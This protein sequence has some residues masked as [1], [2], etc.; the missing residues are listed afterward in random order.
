MY[1][2]TGKINEWFDAHQDLST[3][4][5]A[6]TMKFLLQVKAKIVYIVELIICP[7]T[8][9]TFPAYDQCVAFCLHVVFSWS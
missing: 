7:K 3:V 6:Q 8:F 9:P 5:F 4:Q 1:T 2:T